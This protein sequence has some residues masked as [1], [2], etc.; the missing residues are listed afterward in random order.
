MRAATFQGIETISVCEKPE[1]EILEAGDVVVEVR[2]GG[3]CGSDLHPYLG[4]ER[5]LDRGTV[6][7]HE[8]VG[9]VLEVGSAVESFRPGDEVMSPFTTSCGHCSP[10]SRSLS[11]RCDQSQLFGWRSSGEGLDGA[12]AERIRVPLAE[13]TLLHRPAKLTPVEA[14]LL[15]DVY[16]TGSYAVARAGEI[17]DEPVVIVGLGAVGLSA[18]LAAKQLGA[19]SIVGIDLVAERLQLAEEFGA[20][21]IALDSPQEPPASVVDRVRSKLSGELPRLVVEAVGTPDSLRLSASIARAGGF[22][23]VVSVHP[24]QQFTVSPPNLYDKNL[25][26]AMG[27]CPVRSYLAQLIERQLRTP[28]PI[29][30]LVTHQVPLDEAPAVYSRF[31]ERGDGCIKAIFTL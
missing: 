2:L 3:L 24:E 8:F 21:P 5:G 1:P 31:A 26:L 27:R 15:G 17:A 22:L 13:G 28:A 30:R 18:V 12:Q 14:L 11:S 20:Q 4:R 19:S 6:M 25:T 29:H 7:G 16:S 23:S 9:R 10:C